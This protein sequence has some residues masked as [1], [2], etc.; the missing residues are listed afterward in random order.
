MCRAPSRC[1]MALSVEA[2]EVRCAFNLSN[3]GK[4]HTKHAATDRLLARA[5][6]WHCA[7]A[8]HT[9][10]SFATSAQGSADALVQPLNACALFR[11]LPSAGP[12]PANQALHSWGLAAGFVRQVRLHL[13]A[14]V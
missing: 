6:A 10:G 5:G 13:P 8:G 14:A 7:V 9:S 11:R 3:H 4:C 1:Q 2:R 12:R